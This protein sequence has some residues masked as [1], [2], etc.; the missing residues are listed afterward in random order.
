M[1]FFLHTPDKLYSFKERK[2]ESLDHFMT[3]MYNRISEI[4]KL[5]TGAQELHLYDSHIKYDT[6]R[7][8][9]DF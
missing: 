6:F 3:R 5:Y 9:S 2:N 1:M 4:Q 7:G 8:M